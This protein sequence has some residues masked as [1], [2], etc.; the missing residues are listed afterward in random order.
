MNEIIIK[1]PALDFYNYRLGKLLVLCCCLLVVALIKV[2]GVEP[3]SLPRILFIIVF[4]VSTFFLYWVLLKIL[5]LPK[6]NYL[7]ISDDRI[8][9]NDKCGQWS[10]CFDEVESFECEQAKLWSFTMCTGEIIV[11]FNDE[12][13]YVKMIDADGLTM[14]VQPLCDLLNERLN[15]YIHIKEKETNEETIQ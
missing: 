6:R 5:K 7:T 11:H 13:G 3:R 1:R 10:V 4:A 9:V 15:S 12:S 2:S 8:F 14:K